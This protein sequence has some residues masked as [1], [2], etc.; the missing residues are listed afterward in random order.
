MKVVPGH[1]RAVEEFV[2]SRAPLEEPQFGPCVTLAILDTKG[3]LV[4]GIVY[5]NYRPR[6]QTIELSGAIDSWA[7]ASP[8]T[9]REVLAFAFEKLGVQKIWTQSGLS[10]TRALKV[11]RAYGFT[12]EAIL[13][14]EYGPEHCVRMRLLRRDWMRER[15]QFRKAA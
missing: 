1:D 12:K 13:A 3:R 6:W 10:N 2:S 7:A 8:Q 14:H 4:G 5:H 11:L 9:A 15:G